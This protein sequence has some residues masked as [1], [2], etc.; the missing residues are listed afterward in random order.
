MILAHFF[1]SL[2]YKPEAGN[3][4]VITKELLYW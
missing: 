2:N 3:P 4:G 1:K